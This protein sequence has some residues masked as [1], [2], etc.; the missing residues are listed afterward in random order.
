MTPYD[1]RPMPP[2]IPTEDLAI[3]AQVETATFGHFRHIGFVNRAIQ[4]VI[5]RRVVGTAVT[6]A[7][8]GPCTT[9]LHHALDLL[10]PGDFVIVDRLGDDRHACWGG[11]V[12]I[13][14]K[15]AGAVGAAID[16]PCTDEAEIIAADFAVW[17]RG[18]SPVTCRGYDLGGAMNVPVSCGGAVVLPG[19]AILADAS[20]IVVLRREEV[21]AAATYA[22]DLQTR[23]Q[24]REATY[25]KGV[26]IGDVSG[27]SKL[28][29]GRRSS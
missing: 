14:A 11:G 5:K 20:G 25:A 26:K 6:V 10:R 12:T 28:V 3:L 19:D 1:I 8:P 18:V 2:H 7:T 29:E 21:R 16:G 22:L 15:T 9:V 24:A 17:S 23:L 27:A 13:A 4:P